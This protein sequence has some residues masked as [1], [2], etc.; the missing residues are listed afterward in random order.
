MKV[1]SWLKLRDKTFYAMV[2]FVIAYFLFVFGASWNI[3]Q[4]IIFVR[5]AFIRKIEKL[6][7]LQRFIFQKLAT[8]WWNFV[9]GIFYFSTLSLKWYHGHYLFKTSMCFYLTAT[10]CIVYNDIVYWLKPWKFEH[11]LKQRSDIN[12]LKQTVF[13]S[14]VGIYHR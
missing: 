6:N 4:T 7:G 1:V 12:M 11:I 5:A 8:W 2:N 13:S 3:F 14:Y 10:F 9:F